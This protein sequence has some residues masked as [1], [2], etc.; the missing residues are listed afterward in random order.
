[1]LP[2]DSLRSSQKVTDTIK[3]ERNAAS[4]NGVPVPVDDTTRMLLS[5]VGEGENSTSPDHVGGG[6]GIDD[7]GILPTSVL[8]S[9]VGEGIEGDAA[10][11]TSPSTGPV[12]LENSEKLL[13]AI[14]E[15]Q[16]TLFGMSKGDGGGLEDKAVLR[17]KVKEAQTQLKKIAKLL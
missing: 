14:G 17:L 4:V 6:D 7:E 9:M 2:H 5:M 12:E 3:V 13:A 16:S 10:A 8:M 1:M 15:I 11:L